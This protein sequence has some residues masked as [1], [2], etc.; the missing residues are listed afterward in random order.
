VV[1]EDGE[2]LTLTSYPIHRRA[3]IEQAGGG[4]EWI[5]VYKRLGSESDARLEAGNLPRSELE[6]GLKEFYTKQHRVVRL[7]WPL[8]FFLLHNGAN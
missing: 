5:A 1:W 8:G 6:S 4:R 2:V 3:K 7:V